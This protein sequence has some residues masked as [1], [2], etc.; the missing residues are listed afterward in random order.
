MREDTG[1]LRQ[2]RRWRSM[3][4]SLLAVIALSIALPSVGY[5]LAQSDTGSTAVFGDL[6]ENPRSTTWRMAR[7]GEAG[8]TVQSGP[9]VTDTLI[10]NSGE[11]WRQFR[12]GPLMKYGG[13]FLIGV[14]IAILLFFVLFG[15]IKLEHGRA[16]M[17]IERWKLY[18]RILHWFV[19]ISFVALAIT[20]LS[21]LFGRTVLI[22]LLGA[23]PFAA[24]AQVAMNVH[25]Y[26]GPAFSVGLVI[27]I[28]LWARHNIPNRVDWEWLKKGGGIVGKEHPSAGKLN[29]GEKLWFWGGVFGLGLIVSLSG[30]VLDFP[31]WGQGRGD[32][33]LAQGFHAIAAILWI[34]LFFGHAFIGTVGT[35]GA[36]EG[37]TT[38]RV[39]VNWARQHH[40]L[41]L[42]EEL[43]KGVKPQPTE[44]KNAATASATV[45]QPTH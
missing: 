13:W 6:S 8:F 44:G 41:W 26:L 32:M 1:L 12:T 43:A 5:V 4:W 11:I 27:M 10:S 28:L 25:N 17:T 22:P 7:E 42:E 30:F 23:A 15:R 9:Y 33:A 40:D 37:M 21:L 34:G 18:E 39:D 20:G 45:G 2:Q 35:E 38:G 3:L 29:G 31:I 14:P 16:G 19:A 36:L 24:Y